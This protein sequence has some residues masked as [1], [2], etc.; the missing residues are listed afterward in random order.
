MRST[1]LAATLAIAAIGLAS[2]VRAIDVEVIAPEPDAREPYASEPASQPPV[3][4]PETPAPITTGSIETPVTESPPPLAGI[5]RAVRDQLA[6][7]PSV[8]SEDPA[9]APPKPTPEEKDRAA[10]T[11][12]Y[13]ERHDAPLW[14]EKT[15]L[16]Q[17]AV[18]TIA[19]I[20]R[21]GDWGL[22]AEDF[23]LPQISAA[24]ASSAELPEAD[25]SKA[26]M[27]LSLAV[28][29]YARHARGGAIPDAPKQLSS[30]LD[31]KPQ[32]RDRKALLDEIA[33]A[34]NPGA[35]LLGLHPKQP[36]FERLRQAW[37]AARGTTGGKP[38]SRGRAPKGNADQ[39]LANMEQW[40]LMPEDLGSF[41]VWVNV[42]EFL[43]RIVK[44]GEV[45]FTERITA[46][47]VNKQT[48][49]FSDAMERVTFK[50]KWKVP[51]GIKVREIWPSLLRGGGL[52]RQHGLHIERDG[53]D[54]DWHKVDWSKAN[55][56]DYNV[57]QPPGPRNQLGLVKF[58]FPSKHY[59]FMHDTPDK[60]MFAWTRRANSHGCMRIRNP[61]Q[62]ATIILGEDKGWD[63]AR[64]D[65][66]VKNGPDHNIIELDKKI[67]VHIT[68]FTA[69][70]D[71]AGKIQTWPDVYGHEKRVTLALAGKWD[72]IA[73]SP[74]HLAPVNQERVP[75]VATLPRKRALQSTNSGGLMGLMLGG[76]L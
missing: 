17:K 69:A 40:R 65:G 72:K 31:R 64:I 11:A 30:F 46:G 7:P 35:I 45:V 13:A 5:G 50:S 68:Y 22:D 53:Q 62:M 19:E 71:A 23:E 66:L 49:I 54:V 39:L 41:Y 18:A 59:V 6:P 20:R 12:F 38:S 21:A 32:L 74:D 44:N 47:L 29:K 34:D 16:N 42:P 3:A 14:V 51:D 15:G 25:L 60:Y 75:L 1:Y 36:E 9:I 4:V 63:R 70:A 37:L 26:E 2:P 8:V 27:A 57:Y 61:L 24:G 58:S 48:P 33:R 67:P 73:V 56:K 52:M 43:I 28:L 76:G 55:M 10:L